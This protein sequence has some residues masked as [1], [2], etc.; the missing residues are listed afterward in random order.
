MT[1]IINQAVIV[2]GD[3]KLK[4]LQGQITA[5]LKLLESRD[6]IISAYCNRQGRVL[7]VFYIVKN[8]NDYVFLFI[9]NT[10]EIFLENIKKYSVFS[11][12]SFSDIINI[13]DNKPLIELNNTIIT[14]LL[15]QKSD[16]YIK[17][18]IPVIQKEHSGEFLPGNLNLI[19]LDA[20]S[21]KKGC[22]LGQEIIARVF[23]KGKNKKELA[24]INHKNELKDLLS[25]SILIESD[26]LIQVVRDVSE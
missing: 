17:N 23:Y 21:F 19:N 8:N 6:S 2:N 25:Y 13:V 16:Y 26:N 9:G 14:N 7:S 4:F 22:F 24:V 5:D 11:K 20:V 18:K 15:T 3:D 12:I 10:A 1:E